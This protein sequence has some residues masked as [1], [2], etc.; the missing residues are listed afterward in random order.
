MELAGHPPSHDDQRRTRGT[1]REN[2]FGSA[3]SAG[4]AL[5]VGIPRSFSVALFLCVIPLA[6]SS[7]LS[8]AI[9]LPPWLS[10]HGADQRRDR[11]LPRIEPS[12]P[13]MIAR[14]RPDPTDRAALFAAAS[15]RPS[16][17]PPR[18]PSI[19]EESSSA[20]RLPLLPLRPILPVL[21]VL[22]VLPLLPVL[23][24]RSSSPSALSGS[25]MRSRDRWPRCND[26]TT[27]RWLSESWPA[28]HP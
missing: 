24:L 20:C 22:R 14:P 27:T 17:F 3:S 25:R 15:S 11:P 12:V 4:S 16:R 10:V 26:R 7:P 8:E 13:R 9:P 18:V 23:P 6:P 2:R 5:N 28:A 19:R 21:L 1:R